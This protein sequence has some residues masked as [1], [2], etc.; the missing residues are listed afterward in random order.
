MKM[1][2][3]NVA[4]ICTV[5]FAW[6]YVFINKNNIILKFKNDT[7]TICAFNRIGTIFAYVR[8]LITLI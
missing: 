6:T 4:V 3:I 8:R 2:T 1:F 7:L 5:K